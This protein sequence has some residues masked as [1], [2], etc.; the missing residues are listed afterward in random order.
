MGSVAARLSVIIGADVDDAVKGVQ[1]VDKSLGG[2]ETQGSRVGDVFKGV[3]GAQLLQ[4]GLMAFRNLAKEAVSV[5]A[6][7]ESLGMSLQALSARELLV[8]G[9]ADD[10]ASAME[11]SSG[12]AEQLL[13]WVEELAMI[14]PFDAQGVTMAL[15]TA[16]AY[17]FTTTE[18]KR[19]TEATIDYAS[20]T[21]A[22][23][24]SMNTIALA[25][26][27]IK[28]KGS[29]AG[30][31]VLQLVNAGID[32]NGTLARAFGVSTQEIVRMRDEGLIPAEE[33]IEAII[34]VLETDFTGAA[35]NA[36][37]SFG[38][39]MSTLAE[40]KDIGLREFFGGTFEALKPVMED[41]IKLMSDPGM[42][43]NLQETGV[44]FGEFVANTLGGLIDLVEWFVSLDSGTQKI[45]LSLGTTTLLFGPLVNGVSSLLTVG[46]NLVGMLP[47]LSAGIGTSGTVAAGAAGSMGIYAAAIVA[48][49]MAAIK[50][51]QTSDLVQEGAAGVDDAIKANIDSADSASEAYDQWELSIRRM[52]QV[53]EDEKSIAKVFI[54]I[55]KMRKDSLD[56]LSATLAGTSSSYEEYTSYMKDALIASGAL[57]NEQVVALDIHEDTGYVLDM[58]AGEYGLVTEE[59]YGM[60]DA[61]V[62]SMDPQ[63]AALLKTQELAVAADGAALAEEGLAGA[64]SDSNAEILTA[65]QL[66]DGLNTSLGNVIS[67]FSKQIRFDLAVDVEGIESR[68]DEVRNALDQ[69]LISPETAQGLLDHLFVVETIQEAQGGIIT[70]EEAINLIVQQTGQE[71]EVVK[72]LV[73][74]T[75]TSLGAWDAEF[76]KAVGAAEAFAAVIDGIRNSLDDAATKVAQLDAMQATIDVLFNWSGNGLPKLFS[77]DL[78]IPQAEGGDWMVNKPTLFLA[79]EAGPERAIFI[80]QG[81]TLA[82]PGESGSGGSLGGGSGWQIEAIVAELRLLARDIGSEVANALIVAE[83][84]K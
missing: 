84:Y 74:D 36:A 43:K 26:G 13:G 64:V 81:Q 40:V 32:V 55:N 82:V 46:S 42:I 50:I 41:I 83:A 57:T 29:L 78:P 76:V 65:S 80:P 34:S 12:A 56:D 6:T 69:D 11:Q 23:V 33:A 4:S 3:F 62:S 77:S 73:E 52:N 2:L 44:V 30:Q 47:G 71:Y 9:G 72:D 16:M 27:Q 10:M 14:S 63:S 68:F 39:L 58:L 17:G 59:M 67:N 21:G 53:Y 49:A 45:I 15:R 38:G 8:S 31:E 61:F 79:G 22:S 54:P 75:G 28:A 25:L 5:Y 1:Q 7:Y 51:K 35:E 20:A 60:A 48:V 37:D 24:D 70:Q 18:A 66:L 19:L